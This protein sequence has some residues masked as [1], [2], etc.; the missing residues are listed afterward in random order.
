MP[1]TKRSLRHTDE[2]FGEAENTV[3]AS[4]CAGP[5]IADLHGIDLGLQHQGSISWY[6][7]IRLLFLPGITIQWLVK[8]KNR[9]SLISE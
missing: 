2:R 3:W 5:Y 7:H 8:M 6:V 1:I 9:G 4:G